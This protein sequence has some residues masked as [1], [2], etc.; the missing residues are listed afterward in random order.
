MRLLFVSS[1][2][3]GGSGRSQR[4]LA[5]ALVRRGH[6]IHFLVD[7]ESAARLTRLVYGQLSDLSVRLEGHPGGR[8]VRWLEGIPGRRTH[9]LRLDGQEMLA[10]ALPQNAL[11]GVLRAVAPD[12]VVGNSLERWT[13][14][15]VHG[16]CLAQNV[17]TVLYIR[18]SDSLDHMSLGSV[19]DVLVSNA[20]SLAAAVTSQG[21]NCV[22]V[23]SV[24]DVAVT[25]TDSTRE[26][27]LVIN[28]TVSRGIDIIWKVAARLP[29]IDF[30]VQEA[31]PLDPPELAEVERNVANLPNVSFRS[32][33]LPGPQLYRDAR[34]LLVP[35]RVD[36]RPRV[37]A[38]A[39]ANGIP[40]IAAD[41]PGLTEATG[42]GGIT[43]ET[44]DIDAWC[45]AL[46]D[47]WN[48]DASYRQLSEAAEKHS[49]RPEADSDRVVSSFEAVLQD[50]VRR[51]EP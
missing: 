27:A 41:E 38:E 17:P 44:D 49:L 43:V 6:E 36:N 40:V 23:P 47:M 20:E 33:I 24:V 4:E 42:E 9:A 45:R 25:R 46:R 1:T 22:F 50:A 51:L 13:W 35:H 21:H 12:V 8:F 37:I 5:R 19:P 28:P 15:R 16:Q 29:E 18:E 10:S 2:T 7:D 34:V 14:R 31:W 32:S 39:Q 3:K 26:V 30:V 48:N 11:A